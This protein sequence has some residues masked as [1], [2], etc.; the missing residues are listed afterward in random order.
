MSLIVVKNDRS[1]KIEENVYH[2]EKAFVVKSIVNWCTRQREK[3][4]IGEAEINNYLH[5]LK[6]YLDGKVIIFWSD[7]DHPMFTKV[8][9][10]ERNEKR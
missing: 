1:F 3:G 2:A 6:Q 7:S 9:K 5:L 10:K 8:V 4:L